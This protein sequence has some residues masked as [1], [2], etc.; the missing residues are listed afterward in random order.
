MV[1]VSHLASRAARRWIWWLSVAPSGAPWRKQGFR[2]G[3]LSFLSGYGIHR[4]GP[5][6][7]LVPGWLSPEALSLIPSGT[8]VMRLK[9]CL[10]IKK[11]LRGV[12]R[13]DR[14]WGLFWSHPLGN[15][16]MALLRT[17][18]I[19]LYTLWVLYFSV[20]N[21]NF[22]SWFSTPFCLFRNPFLTSVSGAETSSFWLVSMSKTEPLQVSDAL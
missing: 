13:K 17:S 2:R 8:T 14:G 10:L 6:S 7:W 4:K 22:H 12:E 5:T 11:G 20:C 1:A 16:E 18:S 15:S 21:P 3:G 19:V 9:Q